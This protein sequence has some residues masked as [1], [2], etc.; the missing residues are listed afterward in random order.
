MGLSITNFDTILTTIFN[1][2]HL[3]TLETIWESLEDLDLK[4]L[5]QRPKYLKPI[6][7]AKRTLLSSLGT[8]RFKRRYY[9]NKKT[10][11][12]IYLLDYML[13]LPKYSKF[14][15][16]LR[17]K[18]L[19]T[20]A[21]NSYR[22]VGKIVLQNYD[23]ISASTVYRTIKNTDIYIHYDSFERK[24]DDIVHVQI[25]EKYLKTTSK[26]RKIPLYTL[27]IFTGKTTKGTKCKRSVLINKS[28]F[29]CF[30]KEELLNELR[31]RLIYPY[32]VK[33]DE[34]I[35]VSVDLAPYI[36]KNSYRWNYLLLSN[37]YSR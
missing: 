17:D 12:Y 30:S 37:I 9:L 22:K 8:I 21:D 36:K 2:S 4:L 31:Y 1:K 16:E 15:R 32:S 35:F 29:A 33:N 7:I 24:P 28:I 23:A 10:G 26:D 13:K 14:T 25:D 19:I 27:S 6:K 18:I 3:L 20:A 5:N 34:K 11:E